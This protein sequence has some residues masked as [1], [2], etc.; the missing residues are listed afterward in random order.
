MPAALQLVTV[1]DAIGFENASLVEMTET[2]FGA[3]SSVFSQ[4]ATAMNCRD[5][6]GKNPKTYL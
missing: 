4:A 1:P 5:A 6:R 2:V 3:G